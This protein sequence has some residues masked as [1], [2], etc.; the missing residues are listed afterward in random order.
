[1]A[2]LLVIEDEPML[3][4]NIA[5]FFQQ[6]HHTVEIAGD[7]IAGLEAARRLMPDVAIVDYQ[8][9]GING[10]E[11][12]RELHRNDDQVRTVMVSGHAN[13]AVA[14]DA[15]KAGSFDLLTKPVPLKTLKDVIDRALVEANARRALDYYKRRDAEHG[16]IECILGESRPIQALRELIQVLI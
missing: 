9:P 5:R 8:L 7:G 12:I 11:V 1:M 6:H 10:L 4:K 15:M 14:V 16:G 2:T 13:V 3:A